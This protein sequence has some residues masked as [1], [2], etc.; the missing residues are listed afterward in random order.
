MCQRSSNCVRI[1]ISQPRRLPTERIHFCDQHQS[2]SGAKEVQQAGDSGVSQ[3]GQQVPLLERSGARTAPHGYKLGGKYLTCPP[4]NYTLHHPEGS[5]ATQR[6]LDFQA[7]SNSCALAKCRFTFRFPRGHHKQRTISSSFRAPP[8]SPDAPVGLKDKEAH[9]VSDTEQ[10]LKTH[11]CQLTLLIEKFGSVILMLTKTQA[12]TLHAH[13]F[14]SHWINLTFFD[15]QLSLARLVTGVVVG[16]A[17]VNSAVLSLGAHYGHRTTSAMLFDLHI[18]ISCKLLFILHS[19]RCEHFSW[20]FH[21]EL[22][23]VCSLTL[24]HS[25]FGAGLPVMM[26]VKVAGWPGCTH[27]SWWGTWMVGGAE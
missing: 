12:F 15:G 19:Q 25:A 18:L 17:S 23:H 4:V 14:T 22:T 9:A 24:Y 7:N 5:P 6:L 2:A 27:R 3:A 1:S 8:L 20:N 11:E 21:L 13:I 16:K 10:T 26:A